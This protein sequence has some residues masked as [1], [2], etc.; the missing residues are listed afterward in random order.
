MT[1]GAVVLFSLLF[2][3]DIPPSTNFSVRLPDYSRITASCRTILI[4]LIL[5][6]K[7]E[8]VAGTKSFSLEH[9][10]RFDKVSYR[11]ENSQRDVLKEVS[12][13]IP[14]GK[15]IALVGK[16]GSGKTTLVKLLCGFY[17]P[18]SGA[19]LIDGVDTRLIGQ[20]EICEHVAAVFQ[21]FALYQVSAMQNIL[22]GNV[23]KN[24]DT[25]KAR[26]AAAV[27][28]IDE[29]LEKLPNGY[30]TLLGNLFDGSEE[31]SI[32]QWQKM[33]MARAFYRDAPL[34]L[35]DEPSSALDAVS[36][37]STDWQTKRVVV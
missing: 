30:Q 25:D 27:A 36:R 23:G 6:Q 32:G 20:Q 1:I 11:Y 21:D 5:N 12:L 31:L 16:N 18:E 24:P 7:K 8:A 26:K 15:T 35:M 33:A 13:R 14:T 17:H 19:I 3:A 37:K 4:F 9:E 10:I 2:S 34:L 29:T 28:G 22:L